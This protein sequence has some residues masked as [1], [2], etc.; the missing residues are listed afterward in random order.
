[1]SLDKAMAIA[2]MEL[3][4]KENI[5]GICWGEKSMFL[6]RRGQYQKRL[7]IK[8]V[9]KMQYNGIINFK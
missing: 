1:V 2:R 5:K 9:K 4:S 3:T 7:N 6:F 8:N